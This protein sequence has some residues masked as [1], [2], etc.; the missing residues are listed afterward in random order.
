MDVL[1]GERLQ[2][3][4]QTK[5]PYLLIGNNETGQ[6]A[7]T[8]RTTSWGEGGVVMQA[9]YSPNA[10]A[11]EIARLGNCQEYTASTYQTRLEALRFIAS[12]SQI[13]SSRYLI[14]KDKFAAL[15]ENTNKIVTRYTQDFNVQHP[16]VCSSLATLPEHDGSTA[17]R[18]ILSAKMDIMYDLA[19]VALQQNITRVVTVNILLDEAH[20]RSHEALENYLEICQ[21]YQTIVASFLN[22]L[23]AVGL[24]TNTLVYCNAG[25][26]SHDHAHTY[27]NLST[28]V[29]N[30]GVTGARGSTASPKPIGS[31]LVEILN[32]FGIN[33]STFGGTNHNLGVGRPAGFLS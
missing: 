1:V 4:Y 8:H 33:Y 6:L 28:Y 5:L 16:V 10:L 3:Q 12:N 31:L 19:V 22:K 14:D 20:V 21:F 7:C 27:E 17:S 30:G 29:I 18:A 25:S 26:C 15:E 23:S 13:F 2:A 9:H 24:F 11:A 32:K